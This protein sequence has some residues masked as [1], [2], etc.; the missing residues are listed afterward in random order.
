MLRK[1]CKRCGVEKIL[2]DYYTHKQ[3]A[4]GHLNVC[5]VCTRVRVRKHRAENDSVRE[6]DKQRSKL[7]H[8]IKLNTEICRKNRAKWPEKYKARTAVNNAVRDGRLLKPESCSVC[9]RVT[10]ITGHHEDYSAMLDVIWLCD[11]C[12]RRLDFSR[13]NDVSKNPIKEIAEGVEG[14]ESFNFMFQW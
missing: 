7:P 14:P 4:D 8:R 3:M 9:G 5:K 1:S 11:L 2:N 12:H 13:I 10:R 6:Y